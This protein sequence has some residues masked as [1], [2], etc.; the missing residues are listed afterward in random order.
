M[1]L[2]SVHIFVRRC[3]FTLFFLIMC[4][5]HIALVHGWLTKYAIRTYV[6]PYTFCI[7]SLLSF[8]LHLRR[9]GRRH[10]RLLLWFHFI[11]FLDVFICCF[12]HWPYLLSRLFT[13]RTQPQYTD[14]TARISVRNLHFTNYDRIWFSYGN[15][16]RSHFSLWVF[17]FLF[18][19][20][21]SFVRHMRECVIGVCAGGVWNAKYII[22][23]DSG[24][25]R[26]LES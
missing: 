26:R 19:F 23:F 25:L 6:K 14:T 9:G 1:F 8:S 5:R 11:R 2:A 7:F 12:V 16:H 15:F 3:A 21:A 4:A 24:R 18:I 22:L 20:C 17:I 10:R 13:A